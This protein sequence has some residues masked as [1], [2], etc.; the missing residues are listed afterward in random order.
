M[1]LGEVEILGNCTLGVF[2]DGKTMIRFSEPKFKACGQT[3]GQN[4]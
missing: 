2:S 4:I 3:T 1:K